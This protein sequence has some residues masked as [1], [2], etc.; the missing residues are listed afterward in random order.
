PDLDDSYDLFS[1]IKS[2]IAQG[3]KARGG[4]SI[5]VD[6]IPVVAETVGAT[7]TPQSAPPAS[8]LGVGDVLSGRYVIESQLANGGMGTVYKALDRSRSEHEETEAHVAVKV[9][10]EKMRTRS[11]VLAKLR[12]EFYCA[13]A[14]AHRSIVKVYELD[15]NQNPFFSMEL[16]GGVRL[17]SVMRRFHPVPLPQD[18]V[19]SVV[20]EVGEGLVHAHQRC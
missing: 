15:L 20:R 17:P 10:H 7:L 12:R 1:S 6:L 14:L 18:Y 3:E 8:Q 5:T 9:L 2:R 16:I 4:E 11:E 13:Q 19:W